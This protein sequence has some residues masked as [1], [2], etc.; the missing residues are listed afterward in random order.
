VGRGRGEGRTF[1]LVMMKDNSEMKT[2]FYAAVTNRKEEF[3]IT[4]IKLVYRGV[5]PPP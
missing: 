1:V 5:L 4:Q 3:S 2:T